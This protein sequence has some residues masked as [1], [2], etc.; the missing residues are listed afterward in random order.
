LYSF[1]IKFF[2]IYFLPIVK[3]TVKN[4]FI[5]KKLNFM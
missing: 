1:L 4:N 2:F 5:I 3:K